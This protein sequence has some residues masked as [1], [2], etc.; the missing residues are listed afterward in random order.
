MGVGGD[1]SDVRATPTGVRAK[2]EQVSN[3]Q[4]A[5]HRPGARAVAT[6][7]PVTVTRPAPAQSAGKPTTHS[8]PPT[9]PGARAVATVKPFTVTRPAPAQ[10]AGKPTTHN[11]PPTGPAPAP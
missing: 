10:S 9:A 4:R 6:G 1:A 5:S 2:R 3:A 11:A 8:A 7:K